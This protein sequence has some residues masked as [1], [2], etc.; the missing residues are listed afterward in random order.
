M[1][2]KRGGLP[3][4]GQ[5]SVPGWAISHVAGKPG[6]TLRSASTG[7]SATFSAHIFAGRR[8]AGFEDYMTRLV[9]R[10]VGSRPHDPA[11]RTQVRPYAGE[12]VTELVSRQ[13]GSYA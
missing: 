8:L 10:V 11:L 3:P 5:Q 4:G 12:A 7:L 2:A 13:V 6:E 1:T 9:P